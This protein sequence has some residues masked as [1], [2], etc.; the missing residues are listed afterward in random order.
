[1]KKMAALIL[2]LVTLSSY[3]AHADSAIGAVIGDPTGISGRT[4]YDN[5]HS[6]EGALAYGLGHR[7]GMHI[8]GTYLWDKARTFH[9]DSGP[10]YLY[11]GIGA[12]II[13]IDHGDDKNDIAVGPRAPV[14]ILYNFKDPNI[15]VFG[16]LALTL[17][18]APST[19][20]DLDA[21]IGVRIRF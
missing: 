8:H 15:E 12:R 10:F 17:D 7:S 19:D 11:Y 6:L 20:V 4:S 1:M 3:S 18:I 21:G 9:T 14:G 16:E 13:F 2:S 5:D